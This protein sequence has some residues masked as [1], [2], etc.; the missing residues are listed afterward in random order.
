MKLNI[1]KL[2]IDYKAWKEKNP[3][4]KT[5]VITTKGDNTFDP[6]WMSVKKSQDKKHAQIRASKPHLKDLFKYVD[7]NQL[8]YTLLNSMPEHNRVKNPKT[9]KFVDWWKTGKIRKAD[10]TYGVIGKD[11]GF[12]IEEIAKLK[13]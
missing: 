4:S 13:S 5:L 9:G 6:Y 12:V 3:P 2:L 11:A 1:K 10:G 7:H 8:Q